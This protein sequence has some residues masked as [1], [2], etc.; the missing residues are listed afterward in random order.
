MDELNEGG[1]LVDDE[2]IA[3]DVSD[4]VADYLEDEDRGRLGSLSVYI[5][6]YPRAEAAI[7]LEY[8][9]L[10]GEVTGPEGSG[11]LE[12]GGD[13]P[14][15]N[16]GQDHRIGRYRLLRLL[17]QGGQGEVWLAEDEGLQR[18]VALKL[19]QGVFVTE[20]RRM[21]FRREAESIA[22]LEHPGL[23]QVLEAE[24]DGGQPYIAMRYVPGVDLSTSLA[25]RADR[26]KGPEGHEPPRIGPV[27]PW[28]PSSR[29]ELFSVLR[30]FERT[31]RAL[32]AAHECG[33]LHRDVKPGNI[34]I[35]PE[36]QPVLLDFG[37]ARETTP[38]VD[39]GAEPLT[40]E[41]DVF[42]TLSYMAPEQLR[43]ESAEIDARA[44]VWA[45]GVTLSEA[46]IGE[47]PFVGKTPV[48]LAQAIEHGRRA[49]LRTKNSVLSTDVSV[50]VGTAL[51]P[52]LPRRY[53]S[54]LALAEDLRRIVEYEPIKARPAGPLLRLGRW[55]R[56]EPAWASALLVT[57]VA[58]TAGLIYS[59][60]TL[61]KLRSALG[62]VKAREYAGI[63]PE[64]QEKTP[65]GALALGLYAVDRDDTWLIRSQLYNPLLATTL[66]REVKMPKARVWDA[67]FLADDRLL[68]GSVG[69]SVAIFD[70]KS[71]RRAAALALDAD[72]LSLALLGERFA[73]AGLQSGE[74][75]GLTL[76]PAVEGPGP[77]PAPIEVLWRKRVSDRPV[78]DVAAMPGR[79]FCVGDSHAVLALSAETGEELARVEDMG[80]WVSRLELSADQTRLV[81][82]DTVFKRAAEPS[83]SHVVALL[84]VLTLAE[85]E[86]IDLGEEVVD[87]DVATAADVL[88]IMDLEG[89]ARLFETSNGAEVHR[90]LRMAPEHRRLRGAK[91]AVSP[92]G[93]RVALG[94]DP[95]APGPL[96]SRPDALSSVAVF[97]LTGSRASWT[98][99]SVGVRVLGMEFSHD[100]ERLAVADVSNAFTVFSAMDGSGEQRH[101]ERMRITDVRF[102][103]DDAKLAS[104]GVTNGVC[105]WRTRR[106][107]DAFRFDPIVPA[108]PRP[109]IWGRFAGGGT[110]AVLMEQSGL[111]GVFAAQGE[112]GAV[113]ETEAGRMLFRVDGS[114]AG[115]D[116]GGARLALSPSKSTA[117]WVD[118]QRGSVCVTDL[119]DG[120]RLGAIEVAGWT[121][122]PLRDLH[123]SEGSN[124]APFGALL[125]DAGGVGW[126][127]RG[128]GEPERVRPSKDSSG[129]Q[130]GQ[131]LGVPLGQRFLMAS[132]LEEIVEFSGS[133]G[134]ERRWEAPEQPPSAPR[135]LQSWVVSPS[136]HELVAATTFGRVYRWDTATGELLQ[137]PSLRRPIEWLVYFDEERVV[138][139]APG[140][141]TNRILGGPSDVT[142]SALHESSI[143]SLAA[144]V[145]AGVVMTGSERS[146]VLVWD[147]ESGEALVQ[148]RVHDGAV[149]SVAAH[150]PRDALRILS[151]ADDGAV[152]LPLDVVQVARRIAPRGL[153]QTDLS[154]LQAIMGGR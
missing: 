10:K 136:V 27:L 40:R 2:A 154:Q 133:G 87:F 71:G 114:D 72:V 55:C 89:K 9:R 102:S 62:Q 92:D 33:V 93:Q 95:E 68:V 20:E 34:M 28:V 94:F 49:D 151:C 56:R 103:P 60:F 66:L 97:D 22:R 99:P 26:P 12:A 29:E 30:F 61:T 131:W 44:D 70:A 149:H 86:R 101:T 83:R 52:S 152:L 85:I 153:T 36:G 128:G 148:A 104:F 130:F 74:V 117:L 45:L 116:V 75:V 5:A 38:A 90:E 144:S 143:H 4:F 150:G 59:Q 57:L 31:A 141:G 79:V 65:A 47:R 19:L 6:R 21:R 63:V 42:G 24:V 109:V 64:F 129:W 43:G 77:L 16:T 98:A 73:V 53:P 113:G 120:R 139:A 124:G 111:A 3:A 25:Q 81:V 54:A 122:G 105:L 135:T 123:V 13:P 35:T 80:A 8:L 118:P 7:A 96:E 138:V 23:A 17:G 119:R 67:H 84:D 88:A 127:L 140:R 18:R 82:G 134:D 108:D 110:R 37:L 146:A 107:D 91:V 32:H 11:T 100:G 15:S 39:A 142:P 145:E 14:D 137:T 41:G 106:L 58:L 48:Q 1:D 78:L 112:R 51:E 126:I 50:V 115:T 46:L 69:G 121:P 76:P 125:V 132:G 147:A